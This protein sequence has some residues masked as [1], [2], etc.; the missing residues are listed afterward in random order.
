MRHVTVGL[1]GRSYEVAVGR[2][3]LAEPGRA[4]DAA[5]ALGDRRVFLASDRTVW[6]LYGQVLSEGLGTLKARVAGH[7]LMEPGEVHKEFGSLQGLWDALVDARIERG[8]CVVALGGG[9]VGDLAGFAAAT[10]RRGIEVVQ[11]PTT[12]LAM[13]DS[14]VGGKTAV[15]HPRGKNLI[16]AFHQ[17]RGVL[18]DL[19][20]LGSLPARELLS[21]FAEVLKAALLADPDLFA[22]LEAVGPALIGDPEGL[23]EAVARAVTIKA[24]VVEADET[25]NGCRALLN[26]GHTLGHAVEAASGYGVYAHGEAVALGIAFTARLSQELGFLASADAKRIRAVLEKWGYPLRAEGVD[27]E[28]ILNALRFD[29]KSRAGVPR[30]VLLEGIGSPRWGVEVDSDIVE[31]LLVEVQKSP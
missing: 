18:A 27:A 21:G 29:K 19:D 10:Y 5:D 6:G 14:S 30:W 12:L 2:G 16:G 11:V 3:L 9:V 24:R 7:W 20:T 8:D 31:R 13:V 17:P 28:K 23:E 22:R 26:L 25:E 1:A 4:G 15:D